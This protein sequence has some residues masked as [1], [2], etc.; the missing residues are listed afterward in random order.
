MVFRKRARRFVRRPRRFVR[1][2]RAMRSIK[3]HSNKMFTKLT[4]TTDFH[5]QEQGTR[6]FCIPENYMAGADPEGNR[7]SLQTE[8]QWTALIQL[9][10]KFKVHGL[11]LQVVP[12]LNT[13]QNNLLTNVPEAIVN[14]GGTNAY[15][16]AYM[17][18]YKNNQVPFTSPITYQEGM[19]QQGARMHNGLRPWSRYFRW[20]SNVLSFQE[21]LTFQA[22][23]VDRQ[24]YRVTVP[25]Q[26]VHNIL[27][28]HAGLVYDGSLP[29]FIKLTYYVS[30][31]NRRF[32][33]PPPGGFKV[34]GDKK[35]VSKVQV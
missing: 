35:F 32:L 4:F 34:S 2:K 17:I 23:Q 25:W 15:Q 10:G 16:S 28:Q 14:S 5:D 13:K 8:E 30:F 19:M 31:K 3:R 7:I 6:T 24:G 33:P 27:S 11:K 9:W 20:E 12:G 22:E 21:N 26:Q 29:F 18:T 1:K